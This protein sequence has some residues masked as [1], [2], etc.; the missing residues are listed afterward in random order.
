MNLAPQDDDTLSQAALPM[1]AVAPAAM[2]A[3]R[4]KPKRFDLLNT[5]VQSDGKG[6]AHV[7]PRAQ[8]PPTVP[9]PRS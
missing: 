9:A 7:A 8:A 6:P 4:L 2:N 3:R 1:P 5:R